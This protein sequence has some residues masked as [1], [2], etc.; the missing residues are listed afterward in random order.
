MSDVLIDGFVADGFEP[1]REAFQANFTDHG[2]VGASVGLYVG[3]ELK[4]DLVGGI[5]DPATGAPYTADTLQLVFSTT[6][7]AAAICAHQLADRGLLDFD[8]PVTE[9]WPEF[10]QAGK[11]DVPVRWLL[12]HRVGLPVVDDP[13]P[14]EEVL[15]WDP[16][17]EAL[18]AQQPV[19]E[20]GSAHGYHALT[21][22][23]LVGEIVRRVSGQ[24]IG[25]FFQENVAGPLGIEFWIGLPDR[26]QHRVSNMIPSVPGEG[27][28]PDLSKLPPEIAERLGDMA[29]AAF[30]QSSLMNRCLSLDGTFSL[31]GKL[32]WNTDAVRAAQI[33]AANGITNGR[34]LAKMYAATVGEVDGV[35]LLSKDAVDRACEEQSNGRDQCLIVDTRFGLGFFLP[36]TFAVLAGPG[37]FGHAGAGGSLGLADRDLGI[38]FG[39]VMNKMSLGLSDDPR[40]L[41]LV[42][43]VK[44]CL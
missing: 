16:I 9:Y 1:V 23:W 35:R 29:A 31:E 5:A 6:K 12:S 39:Y 37:S 2:D 42:D 17:I 10:G 26:E 15:R 36:S 18:A 41:N 3:G 19:W 20:P 44:A 27:A 38:G 14:L 30:D 4:V 11:Q 32:P 7:G 25:E 34:S 28:L 33:P 21:Y 22:G 40:A 8:A 13:P 24:S 43:A